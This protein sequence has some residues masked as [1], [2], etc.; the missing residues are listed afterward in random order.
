MTKLIGTLVVC[1]TLVS[2]PAMAHPQDDEGAYS[3]E[4]APGATPEAAPPSELP[5]APPSETPPYQ[6]QEQ[7]PSSVPPG[8]W[9]YTQ[10]YGWIWMPYSDGYTYYPPGGYGEPYAYVFYPAY[11]WIWLAAPWVWGYGPWPFFGV[12]GSV[13]YAWYGH[14]YWRYPAHWHYAPYHGG[15]YGV[16]PAPLHPGYAGHGG[17]RPA[18][19]RGGPDTVAEAG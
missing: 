10:Q 7:A 13:G 17:V 14:G 12:Y 6:A 9:V 8:Q 4:P 11:G 1:G 3:V 5:P 16:R 19:Y 18:P 15:Y 2:L